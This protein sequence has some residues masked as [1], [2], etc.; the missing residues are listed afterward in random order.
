MGKAMRDIYG[1]ALVR[2]GAND[3]RVVVLDADVSAS[4]KSDK[5]HKV[6]PERSVNVGI[7]EANMSAMAGGFAAA[8]MIPFVNTFAAFIDSIGLLAA[9][10]FGSYSRLPIR[11]AGTYG[12][13]SDSFDGP[14][15]HAID[16]L[17]IMRAQPN[18]EVYVPCDTEQ[19]NWIVRHCID[20]VNPIYLRLSREAFPDL[21]TENEVFET[22]KGKIVRDGS[23]VTVI[24]C[25]IMVGFA[26]KAAEQLASE[27]ISVRVVDMFCIKPLDSELTVQCARE[28][29]AIVT[30]EEHSVIGGLG[31]AVSE[32]LVQN[33]TIVPV[34]FVGIPDCHGECGPYDKLQAK[35][36][37]DVGAIYR[38]VSDVVT[39]K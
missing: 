1:D 23:D 35:Y 33:D 16:D 28:T 15:H 8:G 7:A 32:V 31:S 21:Y 30:A 26:L 27:G 10:T 4:A 36:G 17:A 25:G 29:R 20:S 24:A 5:F 37:F 11:Y 18:F 13:M 19:A 14:S 9:R 6:C 2:Y 39:K 34:R 38:A 3:Q 22:G 12:G